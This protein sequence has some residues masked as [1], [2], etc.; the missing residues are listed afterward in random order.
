MKEQ[1][2]SDSGAMSDDVQ[3]KIAQLVGA[4]WIMLGSVTP[5][6]QGYILTARA[7]DSTSAQIAFADSVKAGAPDQLSA[8]ARQLARKLQ[9]KLVGGSTAKS[10]GDAVGDFDVKMIK[11]MG[12]QFARLIAARFPKVEGRL[13]EVLP[14]NTSSCRFNDVSRVFA[15]QRFL[16]VGNDSV[17]EQ[18]LEKGI[19]VVKSISA[20]GCSGRYKSGGMDEIVDNDVIKSVP[21]KIGMDPLRVGP[22][23]DPE[24]GKLF[25]D[26]GR[27]SLKNQAAVELSEEPQVTLVG[28]ISGGRGH[29][30][31][32]VQALE[33]GGEIIQKWDLVGTF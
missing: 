12:R 15:N 20:T 11:E 8:A 18:Q 10:S 9:D 1:A 31:I 7:I 2:L 19:F 3:I 24:M 17:T 23:A 27:D 14:N 5:D 33:K 30:N 6:G 32:E 13:K 16:I 26:E 21:L 25:S 29:R 22:G 28:S 4:H